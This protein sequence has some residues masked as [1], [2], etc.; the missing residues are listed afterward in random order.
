MNK[1]KDDLHDIMK[2]SFFDNYNNN[3]V[4]YTA[5]Q[6][7]NATLNRLPSLYA[8]ITAITNAAIPDIRL[9][10][11]VIMAGNAMTDKVT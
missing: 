11:A 8:T 1:R 6:D 9:L 2:S 10:V 7:A 5:M 4:T 3:S